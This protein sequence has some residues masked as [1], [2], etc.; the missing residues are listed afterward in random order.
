MRWAM[1]SGMDLTSD[2]GHADGRDR[3]GPRLDQY[4]PL[5]LELRDRASPSN[6]R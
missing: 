2:R 1:A 6:S 5:S 3:R 4:L